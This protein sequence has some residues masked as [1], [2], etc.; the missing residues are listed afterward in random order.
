MI[1]V[2]ISH[3]N[4]ESRSRFSIILEIILGNWIYD[5]KKKKQSLENSI[6]DSVLRVSHLAFAKFFI[7]YLDM[8]IELP[9]E[10]KKLS[11]D[12]YLIVANHRKRIDPWLILFTLPYGVYRNLLSIRFFT[13]NEYLDIWWLRPLLWINGCFRAYKVENKLS[14]V[15]GSLFL[16]DRGHSLF[17]FSEGKMVF[18]KEN[19]K[20]KL[21]I[22]HLAKSRNFTIL[23]VHIT[24]RKGF[25][26][27]TRVKW[28]QPFKS[29]EFAE[30]NDLDELAEKIF[31]QVRKL[32]YE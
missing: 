18:E 27:D 6:I 17:I 30:Y 10:L 28:G 7:W 29:K 24:Y 9:K 5:L 2:S 8:Q 22:A 23:P 20:P 11:K 32:N 21:G 26:N 3:I 13:A 25:G 16:S 1:I 4:S 31:N 19:V 12:R 15:K 14:G